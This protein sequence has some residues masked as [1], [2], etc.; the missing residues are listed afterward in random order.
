MLPA[1]DLRDSDTLGAG[2]CIHVAL[3]VVCH[4]IGGTCEV[5]FPL[6]A[7]SALTNRLT[8]PD[9]A[10]RPL[11]RAHELVTG[12]TLRHS[13]GAFVALDVYVACCHTAF[14]TADIRAALLECL[15]VLRLE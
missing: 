12:G 3:V 4:S 13:N 9:V 8:V 7:V 6:T 11:L 2:L 14:V 15:A 5:G 10:L 1:G